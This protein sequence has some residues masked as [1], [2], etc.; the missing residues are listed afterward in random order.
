MDKIWLLFGKVGEPVKGDWDYDKKGLVAWWR[1]KPSV[2]QVSKALGKDFGVCSHEF[3]ELC[4]A[5]ENMLLGEDVYRLEH[6]AEG[7]YEGGE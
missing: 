7:K 2:E 3:L 6:V 4:F 5:E 1:E